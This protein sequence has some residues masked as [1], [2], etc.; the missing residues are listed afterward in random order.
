MS[1][2]TRSL[3]EIISIAKTKLFVDFE[4]VNTTREEI[5]NHLKGRYQPRPYYWVITEENYPSSIA[6]STIYWKQRTVVFNLKQLDTSVILGI[7]IYYWNTK[8]TRIN[9]ILH[10]VKYLTKK[11]RIKLSPESE[12]KLYRKEYLPKNPVKWWYFSPIVLSIVFGGWWY[13]INP[14]IIFCNY[15]PVFWCRFF[16]YI[17]Y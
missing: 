3:D 8:N 12:E 15:Y 14:N 17:L 11:K 6:F 1:L 16:L 2:D 5:I 7:S 10:I 4:F 13:L 9:Y